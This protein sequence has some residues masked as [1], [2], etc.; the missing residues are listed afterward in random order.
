MTNKQNYKYFNWSVWY[1]CLACD[2]LT[3]QEDIKELRR[4]VKIQV[5]Q[6]DQMKEEIAFKE[7]MVAKVSYD[8]ANVEKEMEHIKVRPSVLTVHSASEIAIR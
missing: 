8:K 7:G 4:L 3:D 2:A 5:H 1:F 6:V